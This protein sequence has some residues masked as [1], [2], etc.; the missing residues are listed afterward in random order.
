MNEREHPRDDNLRRILAESHAEW[1]HERIAATKRRIAV[2]LVVLAL[3]L[4]LL[5]GTLELGSMSDSSGGL[6]TELFVV[7]LLAFA[8]LPVV[9][10]RRL[11]V[12][13]CFADIKPAWWI[14]GIFSGT[15]TEFEELLV[16]G[17]GKRPCRPCL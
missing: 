7:Q 12:T 6:F 8:A 11:A 16:I 17:K 15:T 3:A 1:L 5:A 14:T 9:A 13:S 2:V 10:S 4:L